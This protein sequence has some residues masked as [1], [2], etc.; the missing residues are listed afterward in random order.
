MG[1]FILHM[2]AESVTVLDSRIPRKCGSTG[3]LVFSHATCMQSDH[4]VKF[5]SSIL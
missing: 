3:D 2:V 5:V 1:F 4:Y